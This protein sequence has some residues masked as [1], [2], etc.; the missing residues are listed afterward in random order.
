MDQKKIDET[1]MKYAMACKR[2]QR[3][4]MDIALLHGGHGNLIAQFTS[5]HYNKRTDKYGGSLE[6]RARFAVEVVE[7]V[8]E[9]C[10]PNFVIDYRISA[11][12]IIEDGM[13]FEETLKL[14]KI[15]KEHGVDMFNVSAACTPRA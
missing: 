6:N 5:P 11:D 14:M 7:K 10:G 13:R 9:L 15:L 4:G 1:V 3:A 2:M 12:E 8:R